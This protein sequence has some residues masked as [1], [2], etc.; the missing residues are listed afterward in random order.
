MLIHSIRL[1]RGQHSLERLPAL[2]ATIVSLLNR[3][4]LL[5]CL[6]YPSTRTNQEHFKPTLA[7]ASMR[8]ATTPP[9]PRSAATASAER[10][11][12]VV[13]STLT[14][15]ISTSSRTTGSCPVGGSQGP[16]K[17]R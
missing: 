9:C 15:P 3:D 6:Y 14:L 2:S 12:F 11:S 13:A 17:T 8:Y 10:P 1:D 4:R 7:P 5:V 16:R